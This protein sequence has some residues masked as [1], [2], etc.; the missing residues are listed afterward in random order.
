M[1]SSVYTSS[2]PLCRPGSTSVSSRLA[3]YLTLL[4]TL[5]L[6]SCEVFFPAVEK[7]DSYQLRAAYEQGSCFGRCPVYR[8]SL[9]GNGLLV[10][11]GEKFT[12]KPG[13]WS[14]LLG[15]AEVSTLL[16]SF[17]TVGFDRLPSAYP[18]NLQD[19][20]IRTLTYVALPTG[21]A[22]RTSFREEAPPAIT[23]LADRMAALAAGS[24][25]K[26]HTD[27]VRQR[28]NILGLPI[29]RGAEEFLVHL[30]AGVNP[31]AWIVN[32]ARE[33]GSIKERVSPNGNYYVIL[34]TAI[35]ATSDEIL[36]RLR[37]DRSVI[38]AQRNRRTS[39]R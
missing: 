34:V 35:D 28:E 36:D 3:I 6:G 23:R 19:L 12:D 31:Q 29:K 32:Y 25:F 27:T 14:K 4:S 26:Q 18:S 11:E 30:E 13:T 37:R 1:K 22:Y 7:V 17:A 20:S 2:K 33:S 5:F 9:Y 38:S 10:Y 15:R 8:I 21:R 24:G 39:P 16:D